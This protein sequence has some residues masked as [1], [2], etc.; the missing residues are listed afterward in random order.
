MLDP[1]VDKDIKQQLDELQR[2][3]KQSNLEKDMSS[4]QQSPAKTSV[5]IHAVTIEA[6]EKMRR[7]T[8]KMG[9]MRESYGRWQPK[10]VAEAMQRAIRELRIFSKNHEQLSAR[11]GS[12]PTSFMNDVIAQYDGLQILLN[13][14]FSAPQVSMFVPRNSLSTS[15][16]PTAPT[17]TYW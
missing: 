17:V 3:M 12:D 15:Q 16:I 1:V 8:L 7:F 5:R 13:K 6:L 4:S 14:L 11:L 10:R 9:Q 2:D